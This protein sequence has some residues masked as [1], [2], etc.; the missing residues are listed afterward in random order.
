M[1]MQ[2]TQILF[3][4]DQHEALSERAHQEGRSLS[5]LVRELVDRDLERVR[6]AAREARRQRLLRLEEI[7]RHREAA[8]GEGAGRELDVVEMIREMREER[9]EQLWNAI[10]PDRH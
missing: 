10:R 9:D 7:A 1:T 6:N 8:G 5:D 2:R 3:R 4:P